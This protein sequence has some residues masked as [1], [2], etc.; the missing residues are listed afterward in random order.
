MAQGQ[1]LMQGNPEEVAKNR[2][3]QEVYLGGPE[4]SE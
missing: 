2:R 1:L 4:D 3:V